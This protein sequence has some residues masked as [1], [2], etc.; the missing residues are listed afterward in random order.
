MA[1]VPYLQQDDVAP[2]D[3]D[4]LARDLNLYKA[5]LHSP[6]SARQ[7]HALGMHIR[8]GMK[9]DARLRELAILQVGYSM[10]APYEYAHHIEIGK[11]VGVTNAD[12]RALAV[13]TAGG[14]SSLPALDRSVLRAARELAAGTELSD[15]TYAALASGLTHE[16]LID[17]ITSIA[18]YCAVVR[19]LGALQMDVEDNCRHYLEEFPLP[20]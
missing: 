8:H 5:L 11:S 10:R 6:D 16:T 9:L 17:L 12:L 13:E 20:A 4:L 14:D 7:L 19:I 3:Q 1:R 18:F 2:A 15:D